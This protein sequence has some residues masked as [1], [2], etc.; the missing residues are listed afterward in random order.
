MPDST[1]KEKANGSEEKGK[2]KSNE[3]VVV[4][5]YYGSRRVRLP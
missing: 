1:L 2:E 4:V 5:V 3:E